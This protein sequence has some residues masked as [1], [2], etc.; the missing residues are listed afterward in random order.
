MGNEVFADEEA[1]L[2]STKAAQQE[3]FQYRHDLTTRMHG[4]EGWK[5]QARMRGFHLT[6]ATETFDGKMTLNM[7]DQEIRIISLLHS[8]VSPEDAVVYLPAAK[9]LFMGELYDNQYFPRIGSRNIHEWIEV[10]RQ[11]SNWDVESYV[12]GHGAPGS[13]KD[14]EDFRNFLEWLVAQVDM[15]LKK[16]QTPEDV[17][18]SLWLP[19]T[20]KWHAPDLAPDTVADVCRQLAPPHP[21]PAPVPAPAQPGLQ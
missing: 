20:Y 19:N 7:G 4:E 11:V 21:A 14:V 10:L 17:K 16:G 12:P 15:R 2:I 5:L 8:G 9:T 6:A 3:M 13:K 1:T 18:K